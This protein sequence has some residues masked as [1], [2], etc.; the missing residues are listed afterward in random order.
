MQFNLNAQIGL[1]HFWDANGIYQNIFLKKLLEDSSL[2]AKIINQEGKINSSIEDITKFVTDNGGRLLFANSSNSHYDTYNFNFTY[3][4]ISFNHDPKDHTVSVEMVSLNEKTRL[5]FEEFSEKFILKDEKGLIYALV[6]KGNSLTTDVI[7]QETST[8][9]QD[10]YIDS[11]IKDYNDIK[12]NFLSPNSSGKIVLLEGPAGTG[13]TSM[14]KSFM[15]ELEGVFV[16]I[17]PQLVDQL[18]GP[19][20]LPI[21]LNLKTTKPI[22]LVI[23][24]GD[25]VLVP[26]KAN[27]MSAISSLL[28]LSDGILGNLINIRMLISSNSE[29]KDMDPAI[30]RP[31]RLFKRLSLG[32]LPYDKANSI[33]QRIKQT[34]DILESKDDYISLAEVYAMASGSNLVKIPQKTERRAIGFHTSRHDSN[35][36]TKVLNV[37]R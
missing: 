17:H 3:G 9:I 13:K 28:N 37:V 29:H 4:Y 11:D 32:L 21:L 22:V 33:Y 25:Q 6:E 26:R 27:N 20:I 16:I 30:L 18:D 31:G 5:L 12:T 35:D 19:R 14:I 2:S 34:A 1:P 23:E 10:N 15:S 36:I 24:D 7:G 8:F